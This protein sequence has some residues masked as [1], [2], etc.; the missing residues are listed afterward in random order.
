MTDSR[1][2]A[3]YLRLSIEDD[4]LDGKASTEQRESNS[5]S[6]QRKMLLDYIRNDAELMGQEVAEFCDDGFSGT[7]M[8]RPGLQEMLKQVKQSKISCILVKDMSRFARDYIE[9][10]DYLNQIFPFMGVRFIAVNDHYDSREHEGSTTPL[11]TAFQ[12]LLY[13]LYSKDISVKVKTS[14]QNK[15]ANGEYVFGQVPFGYAKSEIEKNT[16]I[17]NEKEAEIVRHIFSLAEKGMSSTQIAKELIAKQTPTVTQMRHPERKMERE[18]HTWSNTAV[19]RILNNRFYLGEMAYGKSVRKSVGSKNG[20]AVPKEE[21]KVI[22]DHHEPLVTPEVFALASAYRPEQST[23]RKREKHPLTGKIYCGG[24]GY[25]INYKPQRNNGKMPNHFWCRKHSLLQ[26]PDCCT[27]FRADILE[28]IVLTELY[29]EL[30]RRGD[31]IK[32]RESLE[33]FQKEEWNRLNKELGNYRMQYRSLQTEKDTLY[34]NYAVKQIEAGEYRSRA[35]GIALQM[36]ELSCKIEE[37]EIAF[38]RFTEEY[39]RPKQDI[40]EIIRF[41]QM[42]K[43]TQEAVDVFIKKVIIYR[44]KR[45]EIEW[46]YAFGEE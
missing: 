39:N 13:D 27:Y 30:M 16:V 26:I 43:L 37:A 42:E 14:F 2:I 24:C 17:V 32:Q 41:S 1:K 12:T 6:N 3:I 23:K 22:T 46:N 36:Q 11:D 18:H 31:L 4:A 8:D 19:R 34:E 15:C 20:I 29:R 10:G 33:Q 40:K 38:G 44:D 28:E 35:D 25:A 21:W 9:L 7:N 45:V 5:I